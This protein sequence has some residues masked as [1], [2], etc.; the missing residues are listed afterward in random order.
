MRILAPHLSIVFLLWL[1][2][3]ASSFADPTAALSI[4]DIF[5]SAPGTA[6]PDSP[7]VPSPASPPPAEAR[8]LSESGAKTLLAD[9]LRLVEEKQITPA[10]N[11][12][13]DLIARLAEDSPT[14]GEALVRL[15]AL[16]TDVAEAEKHLQQLTRRVNR[17][18]APGAEA[19][20]PAAAAAA[21]ALHWE[22]E[23][24][25][26][27]DVEAARRLLDLAETLAG[28]HPEAGFLAAH[29]RARARLF[30]LARNPRKA[31]EILDAAEREG[32]VAMETPEWIALRGRAA[33]QAGRLGEARAAFETLAER[34]PAHAETLE[35]LPR[36]GLLLELADE[37]DKA[38]QLYS[39]YLREFSASEKP[40][41]ITARERALAP[42]RQL[43]FQGG[44]R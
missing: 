42:G 14:A 11:L 31:L 13:A 21:V 23:A 10:R 9:A 17:A 24:E 33:Y 12:L 6:P 1:C 28:P 35:I 5:T 4:S 20:F 27:A 43:Y 3:T 22:R 25:K 44:P 40:H 30:L 36:L 19:F 7:A 37:S 29:I 38:L 16:A 2:V 18:T 39:R 8:A 34:F 41:W 32:R 15:A 26:G